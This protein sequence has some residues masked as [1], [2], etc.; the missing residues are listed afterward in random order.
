MKLFGVN[1]LSNAYFS[2][3]EMSRKLR[4]NL[5]KNPVVKTEEELLLLKNKFFSD[6]NIYKIN[7]EIRETILQQMNVKISLQDDM[8]IKVAAGYVWEYYGRYVKH[9]ISSQIDK[10]NQILI[11][12]ILPDLKSNILQK[13]KYLEDIDYSK[14]K[15]NSLPE[16]T[17]S[18]N[19]LPSMSEK[20]TFKE[21]KFNY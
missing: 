2:E 4:D 11:K 8:E 17:K 12:K 3:N 10:L 9:D 13:I 18:N 7:L 20:L 14:R 5:V 19:H 16:S 1:Q 15:L 21:F 6:S